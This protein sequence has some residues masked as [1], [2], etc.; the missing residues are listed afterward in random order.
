MFLDSGN[1]AMQP[2]LI[3]EAVAWWDGSNQETEA[4]TYFLHFILF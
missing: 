3:P 2:K 1:S 4:S